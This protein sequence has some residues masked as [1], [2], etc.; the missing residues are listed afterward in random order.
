[1]VLIAAIPTFLLTIPRTAKNENEKKV[2]YIS[3]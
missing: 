1:L 3:K 2:S